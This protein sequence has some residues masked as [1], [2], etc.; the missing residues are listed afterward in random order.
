M[1]LR[2]LRDRFGLRPVLLAGMLILFASISSCN[3]LSDGIYVLRYA[4]S[5]YPDSLFREDAA[6]HAVSPFA[7]DFFLV[8]QAG[9]LV[10]IDSGF[11]ESALPGYVSMFHLEGY[12]EP[13]GMLDRLGLKAD[14][15]TDVVVTHS[16]FDHAGGVIP[17]V[18]TQTIIH[19][20]RDEWEGFLAGDRDAPLREALERIDASGRL[21]LV[22]GADEL[23]PWLHL[24]KTGGHSPGSQAAMVAWNDRRFVFVGDECYFAALCWNGTPLPEKARYSREA[25]LMFLARFSPTAARSYAAP[26]SAAPPTA[27]P[28][29]AAPGITWTVLPAHDPDSVKPGRPIAQ[30]VW[31][32]T[33]L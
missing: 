25:N 22:D 10:L 16:H 4:T 28:P 30:R 12:V 14:A 19:M 33:D 5:L 29:F 7:W 21:H 18:N 17:F 2:Y 32:L 9:R 6:E 23:A 27:A 13:E 11:S 15:I 3:R 1:T 26:P 31:R 20:Q 24:E 8:K